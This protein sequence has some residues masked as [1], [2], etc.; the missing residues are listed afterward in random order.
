VVGEEEV[1]EAH[2]SRVEARASLGL[3]SLPG[4]AI[5][6]I[7][8]STT[9]MGCRDFRSTRLWQ[10]LRF[11]NRRYRLPGAGPGGTALMQMLGV[12]AEFERT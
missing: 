7:A 11:T 12:F 3:I 10:L 5:V 4:R 2:T 6:F 9:E 1:A 8:I